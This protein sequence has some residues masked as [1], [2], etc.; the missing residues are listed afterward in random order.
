[1]SI[2]TLSNNH[3]TFIINSDKIFIN[4]NDDRHNE[5]ISI[6]TK[7]NLGDNDIE[8]DK[9]NLTIKDGALKLPK[10][11]D[12]SGNDLLTF[13]HNSINFNNRTVQN[14]NF[15]TGSITTNSIASQNY[16]SN[17]LEYELDQHLLLINQRLALNGHVANK[18]FVSSNAGN[19]VQSSSCVAGDLAKIATNGAVDLNTAKTSFPG[20][21]TSAG[22]SLEGNTTTI[23]AGQASA[24]TAN[25]SKTS[26]PGFG[27]SAGTVLEGDTTTISA[28][29]AS[30]IT[31]NTAK[32]SFPGFGTSAGTVLE[33][34]TTTI[35]AGQ[36]SAIT[37]NTAKTSFPGFG[38]SAGTALEG[39][40]TTISSGQTS[41]ITANT[42]K[43]S[44]PGFGTSAGTALEGTTTTIS[45]TQASAITSNTAKVSFPGFGTSAGTALQGNTTT[46]SSTQA[47]AISS[48]SSQANL[49]SQAI[50]LN[51]QNITNLGNLITSNDAD[52]ATNV[53]NISANTT[54]TSL[55]TKSGNILGINISP[56]SGVDLQV[57]NPSTGSLVSTF[58]QLT[59]PNCASSGASAASGVALFTS[60]YN[61]SFGA[62]CGILNYD[63]NN[64]LILSSPLNSGSPYLSLESN[65]D[66]VYE[67]R[68]FGIGFDGVNT[69]PNYK[70]HLKGDGGSSAAIKI[71][72]T[73]AS[74]PGFMYMQRNT[75]GYSYVLNGSNHPLIL[76]ANNN[77]NQLYLN[78]NGRVGIGT[79]SPQCN[80]E[81]NG[82]TSLSLPSRAYLNS[83]GTVGFTGA[84]SGPVSIKATGGYVWATYAFIVNS[85]KRI[86][87]N[88]I[89]VNDDLALQKVRD[90]SCCWYNYKDR[91]SRGNQKAMGF[92]AQQVKE[93][94]PEAV[95]IQKSII[96]DEMKKIQTTWNDTKMS[97]NDLQDVSGIKYRFYVNNDISDNEKMVELVGDENNCFNFKEKWENVFCYGKEV[98]DF[99]T[100]D[101]QKLFALNFSATQELDRLVAKLTNRINVLE[102]KLAEK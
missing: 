67:G 83:A 2:P 77:T 74:G 13:A 58:L 59:N 62:S 23:T 51:S 33:G 52:I 96:P 56:N 32:T 12:F 11:Q 84:G 37:A 85:D 43:T 46:I 25:T 49:N 65:G 78:S 22:T 63:V 91:V 64:K 102:A 68:Y 44:F 29:Q 93:H 55:F 41:A 95:S 94:L 7:G 66:F 42:A 100:L 18:V 1:M 40:T 69:S 34:D 54:K 92:I 20:F 27:T 47:S 88:I 15:N 79:T 8:F 45:G 72:S 70:L 6:T 17:D 19:V 80:L 98:D 76:G 60:N 16:P 31:A 48:N 57:H 38:T 101:K 30:A 24:I 21:G 53:S 73:N 3:S 87:E 4:N 26:F 35:S 82:S 86:K 36:A 89:E 50:T 97:S 90:I 81:V 10:I 61:T 75:N 99:H 39:D 71:E 9:C 14:L 28:G 5:H